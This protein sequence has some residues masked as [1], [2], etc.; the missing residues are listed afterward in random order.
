[1]RVQKKQEVKRVNKVIT[2]TYRSFYA[3]TTN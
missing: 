2:K 1:M 3:E